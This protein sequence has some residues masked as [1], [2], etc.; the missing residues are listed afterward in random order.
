VNIAV[1]PGDGIGKEVTA[2]AIKALKAVLG[3]A[4]PYALHEAAIGGAGY[5]AAGDPQEVMVRV[6]R[7][8]PDVELS[9][10]Y[11]DAAAMALVRD[12]KQVDVVVCGNVFDDI[13]SDAA[14]M[15]TGSIGM[16]R[17]GTEEMGDAVAKAIRHAG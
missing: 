15:L 3:N 1:L 10:M 14:A 11:V 4:Q 2:E 17:T 6:A 16:R 7:E 13:Q 9:H 8:Y 5:D 12:A